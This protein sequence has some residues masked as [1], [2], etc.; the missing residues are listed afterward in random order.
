MLPNHD[1][2]CH[3][4]LNPWLS[5]PAKLRLSHLQNEGLQTSYLTSLNLQFLICRMWM[6]TIVI[7]QVTLKSDEIPYVACFLQL[8]AVY[9]SSE[10]GSDVTVKCSHPVRVGPSGPMPP[11]SASSECLWD[12]PQAHGIQ[13]SGDLCFSKLSK[14]VLHM[15]GFEKHNSV[16]NH[17]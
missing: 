8:S 11:A 16:C 13:I 9:Q 2:Q 17:R 12:P 10:R 1:K 7:S 3:L 5:S 6:I 4:W 15:L 14:W